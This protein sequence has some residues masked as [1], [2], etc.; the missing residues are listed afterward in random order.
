MTFYVATLEGDAKDE[1]RTKHF[2]VTLTID[3]ADHAEARKTAEAICDEC[4]IYLI[5]VRKIG[6]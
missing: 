3:A 5:D 2:T 6:G 4:G 1:P